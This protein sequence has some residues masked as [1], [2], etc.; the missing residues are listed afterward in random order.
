[1][2]S[3]A[4]CPPYRTARVRASRA[5]TSSSSRRTSR[6]SATPA[7]P[8]TTST[9]SATADAVEQ[10][11]E[12]LGRERDRRGRAGRIVFAAG[13]VRVGGHPGAA[14]GD[15][16]SGQLL[17]YTGTSR[18]VTV[19]LDVA[20][21]R[22]VKRRR[23]GHGRAAGRQDGRGHDRSGR[24]PWR[25][26]RPTRA[27]R[28]RS[29]PPTIE[30]DG[31]ASPTRRPL[32]S[33]DQAPVDVTLVVREAGERAHRAGRRAARARRGRVRR[34]VVDGRRRPGT[35]PSRPGLFADGQV[36]VTGDGSPRARSWGC[37]DD[38]G[39]RADGGH[40]RLPRRGR[41]AARRVAA[42]RAAASWS[43]SS[44]RPGRASRRCCNLIGTLDRPTVRHGARST[45]TTWPRCPTGSCRRCGRS[46]SGSC[47]SSSTSPPECPRWTTWPTA[48]CTR[49]SR[50]AQRRRRAAEALDRVGLGAPARAP[51][52]RAVRRRA[53]AGGDRPGGGR[54]AGAAAGRRAD[55]QPRLRVR[56]GGDG[57]CCASC[58][59]PA[60]PSWSSP[61]TGRSRRACPARCACGTA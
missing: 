53:A 32:G 40:Q 17:T 23:R 15:P 52:A 13:E 31:D 27:S 7:S 2:L 48:C 4:R 34:Q 26:R 21:Q 20:D 5:P 29:E 1:M 11:Q 3:T 37:R 30:V 22:L 60:P 19:D 46:G 45:G 38:R 16:A 42:D 39:R 50:A 24:A 12:D 14:P 56:R 49:A 33:L 57:R 28:H 51:A 47:S 61:T 41:R 6:R 25:P 54:R 18:V 59:R 58:T 55:R 8:S 9:P 36:E 43:R 10:W 44:G 35:S